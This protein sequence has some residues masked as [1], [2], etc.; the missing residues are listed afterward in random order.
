MKIKVIAWQAPIAQWTWQRP[1]GQDD[2]VDC[3]VC[4]HELDGTCGRKCT[5]P[6]RSCPIVITK[7]SHL[8]HA[9]CI[10]AVLGE[11]GTQVA[12]PNCRAPVARADVCGSASS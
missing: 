3:T 7:C 11:E 5:Y 10:E 8:F 12:C 9:H 4:S 1:Q 2:D 6:G